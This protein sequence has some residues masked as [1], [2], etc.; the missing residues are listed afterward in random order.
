M[1]VQRALAVVMLVLALLGIADG[2]RLHQSERGQVVFDDVGPDR[3]L[4]ALGVLLAVLAVCL[5]LQR[6]REEAS[7]SS[8][9]QQAVQT[10]P[11]G[12]A[13]DRFMGLPPH[14]LAVVALAAYAAS[15]P[16]LG[17]LLATLPFA[18]FAFRIAGV[19]G[20][21]KSAGF[22]VVAAGVL[23]LIFVRASDLPLPAGTILPF[24]G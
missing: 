10:E 20:W 9:T 13:A 2:W 3:Y 6:P 8:D 4:M 1:L 19:D 22:G 14:V 15:L 18:I 7:T 24:L 12:G 11:Y 21:I 17:Y 16:W 23:Y 5:F